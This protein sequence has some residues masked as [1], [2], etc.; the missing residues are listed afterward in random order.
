MN[1]QEYIDWM[2]SHGPKCTANFDKLSKAMEAQ[3]AVDVWGRSIEKHSLCYVDFVGDGDCSS[4]LDVVKSK[5]CRDEV[6]VR[7]VDCV[8]HIQKRMGGRLRRKKDMKGKKLSDGKTIGGRNRLTDNLND[9][10]QRYYG[11]ALRENKGDHQN[12]QKAVKAIWHH[13]ASTEDNKMHDYCS[14]GTDSWCKWQRDQA[15]GTSSFKPK[16]VAPAV[17]EILPT[18][19]GLWAENLLQSVLED[20]S[21]NNNEALNHLVWDI[22]PKEKFA[23]PETVLTACALAIC[24][25]NGGAKTLQTVLRGLNLE[26]GVHCK[27]GFDIIDQQRLCYRRKI[28]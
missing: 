7:K 2:E 13:Y 25:F 23:G 26:V 10:F 21:Q 1:S 17:M 16:N 14:E 5:P 28:T 24:L 8:G 22:S 3:G 19:Q 11:K 6:A 18:F 20:L 27:S 12:M 4:P 15:N 9:T